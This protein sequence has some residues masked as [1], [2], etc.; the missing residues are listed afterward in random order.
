MAPGKVGHGDMIYIAA[1]NQAQQDT[2]QIM[3]K[4]S[5]RAELLTTKERARQSYR[6]RDKIRENLT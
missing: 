6:Q 4:L 5:M 2:G 3:D 1:H